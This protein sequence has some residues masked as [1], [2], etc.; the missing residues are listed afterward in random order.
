MPFFVINEWS[1]FFRPLCVKICGLV[2]C[3]IIDMTQQNNGASH[4]AVA[5]VVNL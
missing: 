3:N 2:Y 5:R 4:D 1:R